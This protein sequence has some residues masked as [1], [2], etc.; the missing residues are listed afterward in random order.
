MILF[1]PTLS[2]AT[3][4]LNRQKANR[5]AN[6]DSSDAVHLIDRSGEGVWK[7]GLAILRGVVRGD[8]YLEKTD[9]VG[10]CTG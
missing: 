5:S 9:L 6:L 1:G 10:P 2:R 3:N 8:F 7:R 4:K